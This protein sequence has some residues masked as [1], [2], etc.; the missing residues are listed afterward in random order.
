MYISDRCGS[1]AYANLALVWLF[2]GRNNVFLWATGWSFTTFNLFHKHVARIATIEAIVHASVYTAYFRING[3]Y[4]RM[5]SQAWFVLGAVAVTSMSLLVGTA[6]VLLRKRSYEI[7]LV[8]HIAFAILVI[9]CLFS[10]TARFNGYYEPY[11]WP[12]VAI[13]SFDRLLRVARLITCNVGVSKSG[14]L[15]TKSEVFYDAASDILKIV[16]TP[17]RACL[18]QIAKPGP[19][20]YFYLYRPLSWKGWENHPF[21][22]GSYWGTPGSPSVSNVST[23]DKNEPGYT[24]KEL[25][26]G[27]IYW[28]E[29]GSS[30]ESTDS[31]IPTEKR[32]QALTYWIRPFDGWTR[33]L[34]NHCITQQN[35]EQ[36]R[37]R[38]LCTSTILLEGPYHNRHGDLIKHN[39]RLLMIAGGTGIAAIAPW[40]Q[41]YMDR[42]QASVGHT[43]GAKSVR[44][45]WTNRGS[46]FID[47]VM[48]KELATARMREDVSFDLY[49]TAARQVIVLAQTSDMVSD[50]TA[51]SKSKEISIPESGR[52]SFESGVIHARPDIAKIISD[53]AECFEGR[54]TVLLCGPASMADEA[55]AAILAARKNGVDMHYA[56]EVFGW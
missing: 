4:T 41:T 8:L 48:S 54:I 3:N 14:I 46:A 47:D 22:L 40:V 36:S 16:I 6:S 29:S 39:D 19:G 1:A 24:K 35:G 50:L 38:R 26:I 18:L 44:V 33:R 37:W 5:W 11:L 49:N 2:A 53:E 55:R 15:F 21:S 27:D 28:V 51:T 20:E 56:E 30:Q 43:V 25:E 17:P 45:V 12:V 13:W 34:A 42:V 32:G 9:Y 7:F 52:S 10:H 23:I 31:I